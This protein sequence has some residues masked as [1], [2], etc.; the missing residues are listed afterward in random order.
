M[1]APTWQSF[2][3]DHR[4]MRHALN[5]WPPFA[6]S[7]I[8][9]EHISSDFRTARVALHHR[10]WARNYV[11][12]LFGGALFAM[13]DPF[14]MVLV[15]RRLG[16]GYVVWDRGAEITFLSPG[17]STVRAEFVVP[18]ELVAQLRAE[19]QGGAKVLRWFETDVVAQ[20][21]TVVAR[22]R[23]QLH[24]RQRREVSERVGA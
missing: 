13:T 22:V 21:G 24:I 10:W 2:G 20:D 4:L 12:T 5:V 3:G 17:R 23:K 19:A 8:R 11:G 14:W 9:V 18:D 7:G 15:L 6:A 1:R 16:P